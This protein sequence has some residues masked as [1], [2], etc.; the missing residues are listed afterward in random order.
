MSKENSETEMS[1][2]KRRKIARKK[3][4]ARQKRNAVLGKVAAVVIILA[5]VGLIVFLVVKD[6]IKKSK[7]VVAE[8]NY[9]GELT[10]NGM[11]K[12]VKA[13]DYVTVADYNNISVNLSEIEY[14]DDKV[15]SDISSILSQNQTLET[16]EG[17]TAKDGDKVRLDY[18][19]K[20][21]GVE[22]EGGSATDDDHVLGSNTFI[23][24][25]EEQIV[26]HSVGETFD[27]EVTFP[28]DYSS[29]PDIA[30]KD[31]V[32][33]VTLKGIYV[34]PEF[35]DEFVKEH[36][37][38]Y[39]DTADGYRKYL[40]DKNYK[41]NL[42]TYIRNYLIDNCTV[43]SYPSDY[44]KVVKGNYKAQEE[45]YYNYMNSLYSQYYG[46]Q[47]YASF[48]DYLTQAYSKTEEEFDE[49][50]EET[51]SGDMK[52]ALS[53][54]AIAEAEGITANVDDARNYYI[55]EGG[56]EENFNTQLTNYGQGYVVQSYL[57]EK[58]MDFVRG[59]V[60]VNQ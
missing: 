12:G 48:E 23:D 52:F 55:S 45:Y 36:L 6:Q 58:V 14:S 25:F 3:E 18:T 39:A 40:K 4:I 29:N 21:D 50:L 44:L 20:I 46:T 53:C 41:S 33:T 32:F 2:S 59:K 17:L 43:K 37:S 9:S 51:V 31:A 56:T 38:D 60:T 16:T 27:V 1:L 57:F 13:S 10:D 26:G 28:E 22:F 11:I 35:T 5:I 24:D 19:G 49:S 42:T 34:T 8:S 7:Q 30:G 15:E 47:M 54:Q